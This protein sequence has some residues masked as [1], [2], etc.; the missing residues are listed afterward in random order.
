MYRGRHTNTV[1]YRCDFCEKEFHRILAYEKH[2]VTHT[3]GEVAIRCT[4]GNCDFTYSEM[5]QLKV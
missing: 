4:Q 2:R 5:L 3:G 1:V